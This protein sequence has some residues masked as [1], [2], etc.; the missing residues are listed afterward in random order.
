MADSGSSGKRGGWK[1]NFKYGGQN[2]FQKPKA[3]PYMIN[4]LSN[5]SQDNDERNNQATVSSS[6]SI[7][8]NSKEESENVWRLYFT[9]ECK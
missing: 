5:F 6:E 2:R 8:V 9:K 1:P 3:K 4:N 7:C